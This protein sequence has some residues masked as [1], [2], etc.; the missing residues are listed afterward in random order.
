MEASSVEI[1]LKEQISLYESRYFNLYNDTETGIPF[2]LFR[3][4]MAG[5]L[6]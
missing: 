5:F 3:L 2:T 6:N 1:C 4:L